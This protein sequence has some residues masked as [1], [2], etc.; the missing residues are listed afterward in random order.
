M[1]LAQGVE[2]AE[3][4]MREGLCVLRAVSYN[5]PGGATCYPPSRVLQ[6]DVHSPS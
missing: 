5:D 3:T 2:R 1:T 6:V 4:I